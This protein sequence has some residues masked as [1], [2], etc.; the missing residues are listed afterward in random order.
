MVAKE[1]DLAAA[2]A[3]ICGEI[4]RSRRTL[5]AAQ[6]AQQEVDSAIEAEQSLIEELRQRRN[7]LRSELRA[8][9]AARRRR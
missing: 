1:A 3:R 2:V 6:V 8:E 7:D 4:E 9:R 5:M